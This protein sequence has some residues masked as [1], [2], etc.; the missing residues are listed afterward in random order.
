MTKLQERIKLRD[1][2]AH[3]SLE[4]RAGNAPLMSLT[5]SMSWLYAAGR[6]VR[7]VQPFTLPAI[8]PVSWTGT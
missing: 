3:T 1:A 4:L 8:R 7:E 2:A 5:V 6:N